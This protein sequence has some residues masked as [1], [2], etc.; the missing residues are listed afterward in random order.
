M[1]FAFMCFSG[2]ITLLFLRDMGMVGAKKAK[3]VVEPEEEGLPME[4]SIKK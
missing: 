3:K 1:C 2:I 4:E